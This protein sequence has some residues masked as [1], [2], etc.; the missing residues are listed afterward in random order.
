MLE[1]QNDVVYCYMIIRQP[2]GHG[3]DKYLSP[4]YFDKEI[5]LKKDMHPENIYDTE[6]LNFPDF[7]DMNRWTGAKEYRMIKLA[8]SKVDYDKYQT[9]REMYEKILQDSGLPLNPEACLNGK[10]IQAI[11]KLT[12]LG[13]D[14]IKD[15][16][17]NIRLVAQIMPDGTEMTREDIKKAIE[18]D[19]DENRNA[20]LRMS[21]YNKREMYV[22]G[23]RLEHANIEKKNKM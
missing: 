15:A 16:H 14:M 20:K 13:C 18:K 19:N 4:K 6:L 22:G 5:Q 11:L 7:E 23:H 3:H 8:I 1:S 21:N 10:Q 9:V 12:T 2:D 17:I